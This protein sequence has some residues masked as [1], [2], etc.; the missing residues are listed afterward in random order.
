[1]LRMSHVLSLTVTCQRD[2]TLLKI[3][4]GA[5]QLI[6]N[7][8]M[9]RNCLMFDFAIPF[10]CSRRKARPPTTKSCLR[11]LGGRFLG[12]LRYSCVFQILRAERHRRSCFPVHQPFG[13][14]VLGPASTQTT[15][16]FRR[17]VI[18]PVLF[19]LVI[20]SVTVVK[21]STIPFCK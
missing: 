21:N 11:T 13:F 1:M 16:E 3:R 6:W 17:A 9:P 14:K 5:T 15:L 19:N 12:V 18:S 4:D 7:V 2:V 20:Q 8:S 10:S